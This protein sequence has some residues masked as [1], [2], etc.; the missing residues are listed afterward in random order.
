MALFRLH[1]KQ[2]ESKIRL[3][4][5]PMKSKSKGNSTSTSLDTAYSSKVASPSGST[6][7]YKRTRSV[8][9][10]GQS[11]HPSPSLDCSDTSFQAPNLGLVA[12]RSKRPKMTDGAEDRGRKYVSSGLSTVVRRAGGVKE[13]VG[14]CR[15]KPAN[16]SKPKEEWWT[17]LDG[18]STGSKGSHC[19][20]KDVG[21]GC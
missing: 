4:H 21:E 5:T 20:A 15:K 7:V 14:K 11:L 13:V 17:T 1:K 8:S 19:K 18:R 12:R 16:T 3:P 6:K 10:S 2:W 9:L